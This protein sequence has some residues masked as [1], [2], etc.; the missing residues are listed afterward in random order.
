MASDEAEE[1]AQGALMA[2]LIASLMAF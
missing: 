2:P 1:D